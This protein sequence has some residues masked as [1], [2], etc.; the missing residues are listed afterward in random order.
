MLGTVGVLQEAHPRLRNAWLL[1]LPPT[2][3][4]IEMISFFLWKT[5]EISVASSQHFWESMMLC[6]QSV[7]GKYKR[8]IQILNV[9]TASDK[10]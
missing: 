9:S 5:L 4:L 8:S 1:L 3:C 7:F 6:V 10:I 2:L